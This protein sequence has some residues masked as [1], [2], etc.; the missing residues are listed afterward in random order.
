MDLALNIV[1]ST[2][3]VIT[4]LFCI[5]LS[6][7]ISTF[8]NSKLEL[9]KFLE[10]FN[11]SIIRAEKNINDLKAMGTEV[12]ENL[13]AQIKK[14][15]FL[16]NDLSYLSEKGENVANNLEG[17]I[18]MSREAQRKVSAEM[19]AENRGY[20]LNNKPAQNSPTNSIKK[21]VTNNHGQTNKTQAT[22]KKATKPTVNSSKQQMSP[23]KKQALDALLKEIAKKRTEIE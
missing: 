21:N 22:V 11:D 7:R 12:D 2:L 20:T 4:I 6:R 13:K 9:T 5:R 14:A 8:N 23:S 16:A 1:V 17:K 10:G 18:S 3:L 19:S 15:R